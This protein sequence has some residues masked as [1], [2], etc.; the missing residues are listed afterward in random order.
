MAQ[1]FGPDWRNDSD[2]PG[3]FIGIGSHLLIEDIFDIV[4]SVG[5]VGGSPFDGLNHRKGAIFIFESEKLFDI[6]LRD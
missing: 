3:D 1:W 4:S 2:S 5:V 6:F